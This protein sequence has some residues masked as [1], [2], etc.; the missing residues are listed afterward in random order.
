MAKRKQD[1]QSKRMRRY[2]IFLA[3]YLAKELVENA[4]DLER[5]VITPNKVYS[6]DGQF[7]DACQSDAEKYLDYLG[8]VIKDQK[9]LR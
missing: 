2:L 7:A 3:G 1:E 4:D 5:C 6:P 8:Q 9:G